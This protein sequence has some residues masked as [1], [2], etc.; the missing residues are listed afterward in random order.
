MID[1]TAVILAMSSSS[2]A[3]MADVVPALTMLI[4]IVKKRILMAECIVFTLF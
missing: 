4:N 2:V 1:L 3:Q